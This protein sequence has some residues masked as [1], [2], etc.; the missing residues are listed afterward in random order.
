MPLTSGMQ[1][2][3]SSLSDAVFNSSDDPCVHEEPLV[4]WPESRVFW[5]KETGPSLGI[6]PF[7]YFP[8]VDP[9]QFGLGLRASIKNMKPQTR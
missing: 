9:R 7:P 3:T 5:A 6:A 1:K 4:G 2:A 8:L